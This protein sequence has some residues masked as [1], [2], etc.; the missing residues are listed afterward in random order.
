MSVEPPLRA[1]WHI[2]LSNFDGFMVDVGVDPAMTIGELRALA[3]C[4]MGSHSKDV[5]SL[6]LGDHAL[7]DADLKLE[8]AGI[9]DGA[10][11]S[12]ISRKVWSEDELKC[13][14]DGDILW[15]VSDCEVPDTLQVPHGVALRGERMSNGEMPRVL[16]HGNRGVPCMGDISIESL[17]LAHD[18]GDSRV[19]F[20]QG[21]PCVLH[22]TAGVAEISSCQV[23]SQTG[24]AVLVENHGTLASLVDCSIGPCD[25]WGNGAV[26]W[27]GGQ[28]KLNRCAIAN[29]RNAGVWAYRGGR[30]TMFASAVNSCGHCAVQL[31]ENSTME[32]DAQCDVSCTCGCQGRTCP[33]K[34]TATGDSEIIRIGG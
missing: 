25:S 6:L 15:F 5:L 13:L 9:F 34:Y 2:T 10:C 11:L 22:V 12:V 32:I 14:S 4:K 31:S 30:V 23:T 17:H 26:A 27:N 8:E 18:G 16:L 28:L 33:K 20:H 24:T 7:H 21:G 3:A 1:H 19:G 29:A